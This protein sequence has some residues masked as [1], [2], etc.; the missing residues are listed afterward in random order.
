MHGER[1]EKTFK[2]TPREERDCGLSPELQGNSLSYRAIMLQDRTILVPGLRGRWLVREAITLQ[3][4][5]SFW[6]LV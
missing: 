1:V 3:I 2:A 4:C 6:T 5:D